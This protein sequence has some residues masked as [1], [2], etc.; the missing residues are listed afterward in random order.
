MNVDTPGLVISFTLESND[1]HVRGELA[2]ARFLPMS[3]Y[4]IILFLMIQVIFTLLIGNKATIFSEAA[5]QDEITVIVRTSSQPSNVKRLV[6]SIRGKYPK[7]NV[8]I[9]DDGNELVIH[10]LKGI[11]NDKTYYHKIDANSGGSISR[12]FLIQQVTSEYALIV[13]DDVEFTVYFDYL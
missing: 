10:E 1:Y 7:M 4:S 5:I 13:D 2:K 3:T 11:L 6:K 9:A 12:N 8:H